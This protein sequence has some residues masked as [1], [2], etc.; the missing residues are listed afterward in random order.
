[1]AS[2]VNQVLHKQPNDV[3]IYTIILREEI[4][5]SMREYLP[6]L[7]VT[8][9]YQ[10]GIHRDEDLKLTNGMMYCYESLTREKDREFMCPQVFQ[11]NR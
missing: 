9:H 11:A 8:E 7:H 4:R 2:K 5:A 6:S 1:M 10:V 3:S